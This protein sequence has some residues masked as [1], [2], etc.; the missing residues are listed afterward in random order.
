M[1][2]EVL[3]KFLGHNIV[4]VHQAIEELGIEAT[5]WP[6]PS[7]FVKKLNNPGVRRSGDPRL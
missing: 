7:G 1:K 5:F 2:N 6:A 4:V 3:C